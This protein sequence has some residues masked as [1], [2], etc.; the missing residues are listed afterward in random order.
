[1][2]CQWWHKSF[3]ENLWE[4]LDKCSNWVHWCSW[5]VFGACEHADSE[6][7]L[8]VTFGR[9]WYYCQRVHLHINLNANMKTYIARQSVTVLPERE[10]KQW[11]VISMTK[12][13]TQR[14][15]KKYHSCTKNPQQKI[16]AFRSLKTQCCP[17]K[18]PGATFAIVSQYNDRARQ[19]Q[20]RVTEYRQ[21]VK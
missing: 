15:C 9:S 2:G 14:A 11:K 6:V 5:P 21:T 19:P 4:C 13:T 10:Q 1:M 7:L 8:T 20:L 16:L 12:S 18:N 17:V 3:G